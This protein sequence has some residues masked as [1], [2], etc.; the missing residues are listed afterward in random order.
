MKP[1]KEIQLVQK[2]VATFL[3]IAGLNI[4]GLRAQTVNQTFSYTGV[5]QTFTIPSCVSSLTVTAK[6][7]SGMTG[8][9]SPTNYPGVGG[10]GAYITAVMSVTPGMV[11]NLFVGGQNG[12]NGGGVAGISGAQNSSGNGGGA[13]DIRIGGISL[14]DRVLVAAGGG[15]GT[16]V[17]TGS[18]CYVFGGSGGYGGYIYGW[19]GLY[20]FVCNTGNN[21]GIGG[22]GGSGAT[23]L[24]G[25]AG[26]AGL[27]VTSCSTVGDTGANGVLG[28]GGA[29]GTGT[30]CAVNQSSGGGGGGGGYYGG[31][32]GGGG[33]GNPLTIIPGGGGGGGS[34]YADNMLFSNIEDTTSSITNNGLLIF[35]YSLITDGANLAVTNLIGI[36][37][38]QSATIKAPGMVNCTW[39]TGSNSDSLVVSPAITT[40]Y[41]V[42]GTNS[43]GCLQSGTTSIIVNALPVISITAS[44]PSLCIG[45]TA[46]LSATG[47]DTYSWSDGINTLPGNNITVSPAINTTY[48]ATGQ[49]ANGCTN[50]ADYLITLFPDLLSTS[51]N[52]AMCKGDAVVLNA[53][54][55]SSYTWSNGQSSTSI[56]VAPFA[57]TLYSV[58]SIDINNCISSKNILVNVNQEPVILIDG[59]NEI[60]LGS[61][62]VLTASGASSYVWSNG[63][64]N[65]SI[66]LTPVVA[67][68]HNYTV[69]GTDSNGCTASTSSKVT[70]DI[71]TGIKDNTVS[72]NDLYVYPNPGNG[73]FNISTTNTNR[74]L[75]ISIYNATGQLIRQQDSSADGFSVDLGI[76]A[77]GI[78]FMSVAE[79]NSVLTRFKLVKVD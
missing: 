39:N 58:T 29:G 68:E 28:T 45:K 30:T 77:N 35:D 79:N 52:T 69:T 26:G 2:V 44:N 18:V 57:S 71:C 48:T 53:Y 16:G 13:S 41:S 21:G 11:L 63:Q 8:V 47:A 43:Q 10:L 27:A 65:A 17:S 36:C 31:G 49:D 7:A 23:Q 34:S 32:G 5:M 60:C 6:G 75:L 72:D 54:G 55:A 14:T 3:L 4:H 74:S 37:Q 12:Y 62:I 40:S 76:E 51:Q 73:V 22:G 38:G 56:L 33:T 70:V 25:G 61:A 66:T 59:S 67:A 24:A 78:Y 15:G 64:V 9:G 19:N 46:T 42:L 1:Q 50:S 20:G